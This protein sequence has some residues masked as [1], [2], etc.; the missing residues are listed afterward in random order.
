MVRVLFAFLLVVITLPAY[1]IYSCL[2][3]YPRSPPDIIGK[4]YA[5]AR[6]SLLGEGWLPVAAV[7]SSTKWP[8]TESCNEEDGLVCDFI[9]QDAEWGYFLVI[10]A[11][12]N[13]GLGS[14]RVTGHHFRCT[15]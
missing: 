8:E 12:G 4:D 13:S 2:T 3:D 1:P 11:K 14:L 6:V 5:S 7:K 9:F 10:D 15:R